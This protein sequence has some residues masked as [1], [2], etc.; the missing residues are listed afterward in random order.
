MPA[1]RAID[2]QKRWIVV[3]LLAAHPP[4]SLEGQTARTLHG[5][6]RDSASS[7]TLPGAV[8]SIPALGLTTRT[9][10]D[11]RF[12]L[13][14][15]AP[16]H[17]AL[18]VH[19]IGYTSR[20]VSFETATIGLP[21]VIRMTRSAARLG[22]VAVTAG[23]KQALDVTSDVEQISISTQ[24]VATMPSVGEV[25]V[26]R[27]LQA[28]PGISAT[29]DAAAGLYIR[30]GTPD[31]NLVLFDGMTL[32]EVDHFYGIFSV[33]NA[34]AVK[35]VSV[36]PGA[37]PAQYG[38]R[39]SSVVDVTGKS[40][41]EHHFR[42]DAGIG[43]L[44][45]HGDVEIPLGR[46]SILVAARRSY[47]DIVQS[48]LF[49]SLFD[50]A[51]SGS[52]PGSS[53]QVAGPHGALSSSSVEPSYYFYDLDAK[54][55]YRPTDRDLTA[56]SYY[57]GEDNLNESSFLA[58]NVTRWGN[59]GGSV[60]WF[61]QWDPRVSSDLIA[62]AS[63]YFSD[64][65]TGLLTQ[66]NTVDDNTL[67]L[68]N[69]VQVAQRDKVTGGLWITGNRS[70]YDQTL[71]APSGAVESVESGNIHLN[72]SAV[73][74][75]GYLQNEWALSDALTL[76]TGARAVHYDLLSA[77]YAEPRAS[78]TY[79]VAPAWRLKAAWGIYH[80]FV[81]QVENEN[82]LQGS[83]DFW[84]MADTAQ[85]V[86]R[87]EHRLVGVSFEPG[88]YLINL[89]AYDKVL[90]GVTL[91]SAREALDE[92][93]PSATQNDEFFYGNGR[94]Q[95]VELL[96]QRKF[97]ALTGW[98]SY[99]LAQAIYTMPGVNGGLPFPADQDQK[100][101]IKTVAS[102]A[103]GPWTFSGTWVFGSGHPYT[104]PESEYSVTLL[105]G[106]VENYIHVSG[107][108]AERFPPYQRLDLAVFRKF[109]GASWFDW[110]VSV[111]VFNVYNHTNVWYRTFDTSTHPIGITDVNNL[112]FTPSLDLSFSLR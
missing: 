97:G 91:V 7:E 17:Y 57:G 15:V 69:A 23:A 37:Y 28:L 96:L 19:Y 109:R 77:W 61:H 59:N 27:A 33:F 8:V 13:V 81:N 3:C 68:D 92:S 63:R 32:Y 36:Y 6:V 94:E 103:L 100:H 112:G 21:I 84:L 66:D 43:L 76:T 1:C 102:Y 34:D 95:G 72:T 60:R 40:G 46:G 11:G 9:N 75:A 85:P 62:S 54:W 74:A 20:D 58:G 98:V 26:F 111:S 10:T 56:V 83:R 88:D 78:V 70:A 22:K 90:S 51:K 79:R 110:Q 14:D 52:T 80:Q 49:N 38:A 16:G 12:V 2:M 108:N 53:G 106:T 31:Q 65:T 5:V 73:L 64:G 82:V 50:F 87:A 45:G 99:T 89:E 44:S 86:T 105:D 42:A 30:G 55:S 41:D 101:E 35:D 4:H 107:E 48:P 47:S 93:G 67:R 24:Q 39:V 25:D 29:S 104:A 18:R 71:G